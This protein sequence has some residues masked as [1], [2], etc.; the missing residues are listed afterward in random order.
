M[1][2]KGGLIPMERMCMNKKHK[3]PEAAARGPDLKPPKHHL[4]SLG[5]RGGSHCSHS[6]AKWSLGC[7]A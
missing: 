7:R 2:Q 1:A 5:S 4:S 3:L 6:T